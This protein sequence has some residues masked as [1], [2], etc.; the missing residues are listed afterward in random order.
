MIDTNIKKLKN[1]WERSSRKWCR[2]IWDEY[3]MLAV[4]IDTTVLKWLPAYEQNKFKYFKKKH[5][6]GET[7]A[8]LEKAERHDIFF[9]S[10]WFD[11][12]RPIITYKQEGLVGVGKD[13]INNGFIKA[14]GVNE[15]NVEISF[16][17][18]IDIDYFSTEVVFSEKDYTFFSEFEYLMGIKT[19][20]VHVITQGGNFD[21]PNPASAEARSI[22]ELYCLVF[23]KLILMFI[24]LYFSMLAVV[25]FFLSFNSQNKKK[26]INYLESGINFRYGFLSG[27]LGFSGLLN[28]LCSKETDKLEKGLSL[29]SEY[30]LNL[31]V[32]VY[33][34]AMSNTYWVYNSKLE[35]LWTLI[36]CIFLLIISLPSFT[37]ALALDETN[38]PD[39]WIKV[40]GNQWFW[41][42][43]DSK[44]Q[45]EDIVIYC[46]IVHGSDLSVAGSLR[47]LQADAVVTLSNNKYT[48]LL[49]TS[50]DVIHSLA[51]P[52][53][54]IKVDACPGR[55]NAITVLPTRVGVYYGQCSE[56]C[57][58]NHA[59]MPIIFQVVP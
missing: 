49:V 21:F 54:G 29:I 46:N 6:A 57:G 43:E 26:I 3:P 7:Y 59:F 41:V 18:I 20:G 34:F 30:L 39:D 44:H 19:S 40:I 28:N 31:I 2:N 53:M 10:G 9:K 45:K 38:K 5:F 4:F 37:L 35:F 14:F 32:R 25:S 22:F 51:V 16:K 33:Q 8:G 58:V 36:P 50:S 13:V 11:I 24:F 17:K 42:Y 12:R 47:A 23:V 15:K 55:I 48:R 1:S 52:S 27:L 56:I